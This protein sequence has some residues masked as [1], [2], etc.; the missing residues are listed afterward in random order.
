MFSIRVSFQSHS[1]WHGETGFTASHLGLDRG[2]CIPRNGCLSEP[3]FAASRSFK[4]PDEDAFQISACVPAAL[5]SDQP[6]PGNVLKDCD[7]AA[8]K[9]SASCRV[10][11]HLSWTDSRYDG[12]R[13]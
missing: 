13:V 11:T 2:C 1:D 5:G 12:I 3:S 7:F 4:S 6:G 8:R 10:A 9:K